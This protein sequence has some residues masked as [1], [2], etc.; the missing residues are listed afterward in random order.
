MNSAYRGRQ[1]VRVLV[2]LALLFTT[3]GCVNLAANLI[4]AVQGNFRP[5]EFDGLKGKRVA[6]VCTTDGGFGNGATNSIL[7]NNI[8][9][10]LGMNVKD[11]QLVRNSEID[12][13]L[14]SH[15]RDESDYYEIGRGVDAELLVAVELMDMKLKNGQTL[16]KGEADITVTVY[17]IKKDGMILY[18]KQI[19]EFAF[20]ES[21]GKPTT[22]TTETKFRSFFLAVVTRRVAGLFYEVDATADYALDATVSS[23]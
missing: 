13:W 20:P 17:D 12:Q 16:F 10:A 6:V 14:D 23:F 9:A 2:A 4:H 19:P 18:R 21:D 3:G 15:G 7:T 1:S 11:I 5:A 8:H 22:E